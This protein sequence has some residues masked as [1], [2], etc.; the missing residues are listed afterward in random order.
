M[1]IY[2]LNSWKIAA[3]LW[4]LLC[5][6]A[7]MAIGLGPIE[8]LSG[9]NQPFDARI[10]LTADERELQ[11]LSVHLAPAK[12]FERS[13]LRLTS[14]VRQLKFNVESEADAHYITVVGTERV[15]EPVVTVLLRIE[16]YGGQLLRQYIIP[17]DQPGAGDT[18]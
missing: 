17:M 5:P 16:T 8:V 18:P 6:V 11:R 4:C 2:S 7:A 1:P 9:F 10:P 3:A 12:D 15:R 13:G 14:A